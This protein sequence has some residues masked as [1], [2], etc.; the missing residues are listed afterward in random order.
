MPFCLL[1]GYLIYEIV[2]WGTSFKSHLNKLQKI[3][4]K[5]PHVVALIGRLSTHVNPLYFEHKILKV[6][7]IFK[8]KTSKFVH[9]LINKKL[10]NYFL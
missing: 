3:Q 6:Y 4:H 8:L 5:A 7:D 10:Q 2:L 1:S 9:K